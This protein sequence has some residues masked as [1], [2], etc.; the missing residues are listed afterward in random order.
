M[1]HDGRRVGL[2]P[3]TNVPRNRVV[4][5]LRTSI[6]SQWHNEDARHSQSVTWNLVD[7]DY[8]GAQREKT[9]TCSGSETRRV[10][11]E[12]TS[13]HSEMSDEDGGKRPKSSDHH[14]PYASLASPEIILIITESW[15]PWKP[16]EP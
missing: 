12:R 3:T 10:D 9:S 11:V 13:T 1:C 6:V 5:W 2:V 14:E 4:P 7:P 15:K 16:W 8:S